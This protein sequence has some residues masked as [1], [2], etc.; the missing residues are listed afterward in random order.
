MVAYW[1]FRP[2][3]VL[4]LGGLSLFFFLL[5]RRSVMAEF[6]AGVPVERLRPRFLSLSVAIIETSGQILR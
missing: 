4:H 5:G 1:F 6:P 2:G 3:V